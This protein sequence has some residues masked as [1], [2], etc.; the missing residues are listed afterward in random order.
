MRNKAFLLM[1]SPCIFFPAI[2]NA[3][4][5]TM[6][7]T[8]TVV[9]S[10]CTVKSESITKTIALDGGNG[11]Q[12]KDLQAAGSSTPWVSFDI[13]IADCPAG[14]TQAVVTFTGTPDPDEPADMYINSGTAEN[15][16]VQLQGSGGNQFGDG[17]T[18]T[19]VIA[20]GEYTY[21]LKSR[22]YTKNGGVTPGTIQ[23]VV[24]ANFTYQ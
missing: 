3:A 11:F 4:D 2:S 1:L 10:P 19:G 9:A 17:K 16:G 21:H 18:F 7:L 15:V 8:A 22:A 12:A 13:G 24:T 5:S 14:T 6:A 23:A 20:N